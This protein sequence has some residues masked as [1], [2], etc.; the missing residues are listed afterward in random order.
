M[1][2]GLIAGMSILLGASAVTA[3]TPEEACAADSLYLVSPDAITMA[4]QTTGRPGLIISWEDLDT[5]EATCF[6]LTGDD[7]IGFSIDVEG[8]FGDQV[9]RFITFTT[10]DAGTIGHQGRTTLRL[11]WQSQGNAANGVLA[12]NINLA[13][14]GGILRH[15]YSGGQ[16]GQ[17]NNGLPM[18]WFQTNVTALA[19]G[20]GGFLVAIFT[21]GQTLDSNPKGLWVYR[22]GIWTQVGTDTFASTTVFTRVA[23]SP[24]SNDV[25]AVGTTRGG[26]YVT[27]DG[28]ETFTQFT[29]NLDP[30]HTPMPTNF[31]VGALNWNSDRLF[32]FLP[33]FGLFRSEDGGNSFVRSEIEVEDDLDSDDPQL[34]PPTVLNEIAV[35]P[36]DPDHVLVSLNFNG[37]WESDDGGETWHDLYGDLH[38]PSGDDD[39]PGEWVH[40]AKSVAV[41]AGNSQIMVAGYVQEGLYR[42]DDGGQT[43]TLVGANIQPGSPPG[44]ST[45]SLTNLYVRSDPDRPGLFYVL[46]DN[47]TLAVS[48]DSGVTWQH[49]ASQPYLIKGRNLLVSRDGSGDLLMASYAGGIYVPGSPV[50]LSD[51]YNTTTSSFLRSLDLGLDITFGTGDIVA[52]DA[53]NLVCQTFQ[54]WAVWRSP[55]H[56][57]HNMTLLGMYDRVNPESCIEGYCGDESYDLVPQCYVSKRASCFSFDTADTIRF[58]DDE[59]YNGFSYYYAVSTFDYGNTAMTSPQNN[60]NPMVFSPRFQG[61]DL[62]PFTGNGNTRFIQINSAPADPVQDE[63]IYVYPNPLRRDAGIPGSEGETVIFTNLPPQSRVRVFTT[64]G[65][66]V[67]NLGWDNMREGNIYWRTT[68]REGEPVSPGVYLYKVESPQREDHWGKLVIIR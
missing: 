34:V 16:W 15:G 52:N 54:G 38:V 21:A 58:F 10:P 17:T 59:V 12:G 37:V 64:A 56:D 1:A 48:T 67:I 63:T 41:D 36:S 50:H 53:F 49:L 31:S 3:Q 40:S 68:N 47:H 19:E 24:A 4:Q 25:F 65:D 27:Q 26:L 20:S 18:T 57:R 45:A 35:D 13:N 2:L 61:D 11:N 43:W 6:T 44:S 62:S 30:D 39:N 55:A 42:T 28:G 14:N 32:V 66:D 51:T 9:D 29:S 7:N 5:A 60:T 8:G 33:N 46:E 22:S 23:V